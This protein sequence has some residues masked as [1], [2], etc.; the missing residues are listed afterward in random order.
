MSSPLHECSVEQLRARLTSAELTALPDAVGVEAGEDEAVNAWLL[1]V[2]MAACDRVVAAV[3]AC[4]RNARIAYGRRKVPE[5]C[6]HTALVLARHAVISCIPGM[7]DVLEGSS[8][9]AE[10][11]TAVDDLRRLAACELDAG[12]YGDTEDADITPAAG[13]YVH[14]RPAMQF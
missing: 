8:R 12:D 3:N 13:V 5:S 11:K 9:A 7:G 6:V 10:Y 1:E 14:S 4:E 2:L